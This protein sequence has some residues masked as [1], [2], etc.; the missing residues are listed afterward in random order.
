MAGVSL[1]TLAKHLKVSRPALN[2]WAKRGDP[3]ADPA[4]H[5]TQAARVGLEDGPLTAVRI[6]AV[7]G[8]PPDALHPGGPVPQ[9]TM[10]D[11]DAIARVAMALE[12]SPDAT[13]DDVLEVVGRLMEAVGR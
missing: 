9:W 12:L 2:Y 11:V 10:R 8:C 13:V 4:D 3:V 1:T 6:A 7:L 5:Q